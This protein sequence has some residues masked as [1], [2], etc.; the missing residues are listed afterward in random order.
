[1]SQHLTTTHPELTAPGVEAWLE[2]EAMLHKPM[3]TKLFQLETTSRLYEDDSSVAGI[4]Y[5]EEVNEAGTS[6]EDN[7]TLGYES[8]YQQK[9]FKKKISVSKLLEKTD[10]YSIIDG[11]KRTRELSRKAA[12]SRDIRAFEVLRRG[13][14]SSLTYGDGKSLISTA[15]P[16]KDG[17]A[18]QSNTFSDGIQRSLSYD[19]A[20][21]MEDQIM[22]VVSNSGTPIDVAMNG[23]M[24][25]V[26][27]PYNR[28]VALQIA[29]TED[30]RPGEGDH[31][32]N[33]W[34]GRSLDVME[35]PYM[36][37]RY[38]RA[39]GETTSTDRTTYDQRWFLIDPY[40]AKK[41]LKFKQI[42]D[43]EIKSWED[44]DTDVMY[45]KVADIFAVGTSG[46][47]GI[48]GSLGDNTTL[49][50]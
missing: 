21:E 50:V 14:D 13:F 49:S 48:G 42:Q 29:E 45:A 41:V 36:S 33:Y 37:H 26:V 6:P 1:M 18:S 9:V 25:L 47:Y 23:N 35:V 40:Y 32:V 15:H 22:E 31:G 20:K 46:W 38:A 5:L 28:E 2:E 30:G 4:G 34:K 10:L 43:F 39:M 3:F 44:E 7:F 27:T 11:E 24:V 19:A 16:R 8:R 12:Q 17:G